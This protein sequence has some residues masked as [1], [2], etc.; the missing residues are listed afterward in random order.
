MENSKSILV[1]IAI[2]LALAFVP[3]AVVFVI[4]ICCFLFLYL[5]KKKDPESDSEPPYRRGSFN[6]TPPRRP[7]SPKD[8]PLKAMGDRY[9]RYI[10]EKLEG[11]GEVVIY[12]GF[13]MGYSDQG[14]DL[15]SISPTHKTINLIQCK[16]WKKMNMG[17]EV[18]EDIYNKLS[19]YFPAYDPVSNFQPSTI[20][21]HVSKSYDEGL[22]KNLMTD[23]KK[24]PEDYKIRKTLYASSD[25]V[26]DLEV[27]RHVKMIKP[28]IF[29]YKEMKIVFT[30]Q[31]F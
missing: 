28:S 8:D 16:N 6:H 1:I 3:E 22:L 11:K 23:I 13:I 18:I 9:E 31:P 26:I 30:D 17:V 5:F 12:N 19:K 4:I 27:G 25:Q 2:I 21:S 29:R 20:N 24:S 10:G 14:V 7:V 15:I